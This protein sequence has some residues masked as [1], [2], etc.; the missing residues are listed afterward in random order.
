MKIL[1]CA[2]NH[3]TNEKTFQYLESIESSIKPDNFLLRVLIADNS[4]YKNKPLDLDK[5]NFEVLIVKTEN[6]GYINSIEFAL[7]KTKTLRNKYDYFIISNVDL[8]LERN[9]FKI[10][11]NLKVDENIGWIAPQIFS[12]KELTDR[13]PKINLRLTKSSIMFLYFLYSIPFLFKI[14]SKFLYPIRRKNKINSNA[15]F[16][17]A[18]HGSFMIFTKKFN[19][20]ISSIKYFNFLFNEEIF[21]AELC[22]EANLKVIHNKRLVINDFDHASTSKINFLKL[23]RLNKISIKNIIDRYYE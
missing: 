8:K 23:M 11:N 10:L 16:I 22:R 18:G 5:F 19:E 1:I 4:S 14:Y 15:K 12:E 2:T 21:F 3:N 20:K 7:N 17:Y 9:F 13:N 6:L